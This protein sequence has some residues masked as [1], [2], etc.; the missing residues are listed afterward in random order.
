MDVSG[1][2]KLEPVSQV[3]QHD[4]VTSLAQNSPNENVGNI[5]VGQLTVDQLKQVRY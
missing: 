5:N 1:T 3:V 4:L 2:Q